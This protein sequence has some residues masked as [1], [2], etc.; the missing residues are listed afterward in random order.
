MSGPVHV[1]HVLEATEGG[2]RR[3]LENVLFGLD[4]SRIR[5]SCICSVRRDPTFRATID[6]FRQNNI[7]MWVVDMKRRPSP[8]VDTIGLCRI[9]RILRENRFDIVHAHSSKA[10]MLG[11]LAAR[12]AGVRPVVYT[13]HAYAFQARSPFSCGYRFLERLA[14]RWAEKVVAVS[15][16]EAKISLQ[17]GYRPDQVVTIPNGVPVQTPKCEDKVEAPT[18]IGFLAALRPQK[19]PA[20][21]IEAGRLLLDRHTD[22]RFV[23][24]GTGPM[25]SNLQR[26]VRKWGLEN[27]FEFK[28]RVLDARTHMRS[29]DV[30]VLSSL[31]EGLPYALLEAMAAGIPVVATRVPGVEEVIE[32][33]ETGLLVDPASPNALADAVERLL[34]DPHE[35]REMARKARETVAGRYSLDDQLRNLTCFYESISGKGNGSDADHL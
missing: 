1:L 2:T 19:D 13:P 5:S 25:L 3:W 14:V 17:L 30:F 28:G 33:G 11:R 27:A 23:M 20:T 6:T 26:Q 16:A 34:R 4:P 22:L 9:V 12:I 8:L 7:H 10:G 29:W 35:G 32:D 15:E 21:F 31:Y 18:V 24:F